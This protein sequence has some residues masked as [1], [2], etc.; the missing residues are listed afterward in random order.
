M[1]Y[2]PG[3]TAYRIYRALKKHI[4]AEGLTF[5]ELCGFVDVEPGD[6]HLCIGYLIK[7]GMV[8][9]ITKMDKYSIREERFVLSGGWM[10]GEREGGTLCSCGCKERST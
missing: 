7:A 2:K 1:D 8:D 5:E 9:S 3:I 4:G 10:L 6:L